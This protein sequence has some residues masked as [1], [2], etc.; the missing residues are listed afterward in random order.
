[1]PLPYFVGQK[2][3]SAQVQGEE[4]ILKGDLKVYLPQLLW[5][6]NR[7][8]DPENLKPKIIALNRRVGR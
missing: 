7:E 4:I 3:G 5:K 1:M 8:Q 6:Q 2:Q